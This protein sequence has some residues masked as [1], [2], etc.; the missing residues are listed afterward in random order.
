VIGLGAYDSLSLAKTF[1]ARNK[2]SKVKMLWDKNAKSWEFYGVPGQPAALLIKN[3]EVV[4]SWAGA[5]D[6]PELLELIAA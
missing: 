3:G 1:T 2:M 4:A 5:V 6:E